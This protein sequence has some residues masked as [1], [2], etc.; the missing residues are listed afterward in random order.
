[1]KS[2]YQRL[3][4]FALAHPILSPTLVGLGVRLLTAYWGMG[5]HARDDYFHVLDPALH[6]VADPNFNWDTSSSPAPAFALIWY[7]E[8]CRASCWYVIA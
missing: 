1:M 7:R 6:W 3:V 5:F 8:L 2:I 4:S